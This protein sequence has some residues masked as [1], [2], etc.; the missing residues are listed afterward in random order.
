M[1]GSGPGGCAAALTAARRGL[2][3]AVV[4]RGA[5]GGVC[6]NVGCIPTKALISVARFWR[7]IGQAEH[8]GIRVAGAKLDWPAVMAR[9]S[10]IVSG[11]RDGLTELLRR[12]NVERIEG[13]AL[14]KDAHTVQVTNGSTSRALKPQRVV[15]A[16][17]SR[18]VSG[19]WQ[20]DE[21]RIVSYRGLL[22]MAERPRSLLVIGGGVI[23]CE[24]ASLFSAFGT[25]VTL[26][27]QQ[28]S[29]LP[30]ED[31]EA[32]SWL[33]RRL[34]ASKVRVLTGTT[35]RSL[36]SSD[37]HVDAVFSDETE[38][39]FDAALV[40][41]GY[42]PAIDS[43]G[44][45]AAGIAAD[46]GIRVDAFLRTSQPHIAAIGDC[47]QGRGLAHWA[48][49]EGRLAVENLLGASQQALDATQVPRC[50]YT[51]PEIASVG[52]A[53]IP[54][55]GIRISRLFMAAIGKNVC[56]DETDGIV[57]LA[58]EEGTDRVVGASIVGEQASALIHVVVL[59][60]HHGLTAKQL[61][62]TLTAHPS[63]AEAVTETAAHVYG[64]SL[65]AAARPARPSAGR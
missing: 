34:E 1:I 56:D 52:R 35:I 41:V 62:H 8:L 24:F 37:N 40:A 39:R 45:D 61:A 38:A 60:M 15:I 19:P 58:V 28:Q 43:L 7:R 65:V 11:L 57:K 23:G 20:L 42:Q 21:K 50:I 33:L 32:V 17:G 9:N 25:D 55:E 59:A 12:E 3:T 29:V 10:R 51:D 13:T 18:P 53:T 5:W 47:L 63:L 31:P 26:V 49:A 4:E 44:L 30:A 46:R 48:A 2:R 14:F 16:T 54:A 27:E 22:A 64:E 6:L 36:T